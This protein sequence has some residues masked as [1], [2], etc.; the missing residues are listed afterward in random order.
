MAG[1]RDGR[2]KQ[3]EFRR[4]SPEE[5]EACSARLR[6]RI[7]EIQDPGLRSARYDDPRVEALESS[8]RATVRD[9]FG[10]VSHEAGEYGGFRFARQR[11]ARTSNFLRGTD[12]RDEVRAD[13][14]RQI[15]ESMPGAVTRLEGLIQR[16]AERTVA[17][18]ESD[19]SAS[20]AA[21]PTSRS[22]FLV[23]GHNEEVKQAVARLLE[24]LHLQP[25]ILHEQTDMNR[26]IIE[27]FEAHAD[28]GFAVILMTG[29]DRGGLKAASADLYQ[30]RA[31]QNVVLEMGFFLG[32]LGRQRVCVLYERGVEMP[33][34]YSGVLFKPLDS[35][36]WR[37]E[38]AREI[39]A[40]GIPVDFNL[41]K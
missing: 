16:I 41:L 23:H 29:D 14:Q 39:D 5:A 13:M 3:D 7:A 35:D 22:V 1:P 24:R 12:N 31:R 10:D 36:V 18:R 34:D 9:I 4:F 25:I 38:L 11:I 19:R 20:V 37:W 40:A 28:V 33:S 30:P 21:A 2:P 8:I 26:T 32:R 27:K 17:A 15:Q 6:S